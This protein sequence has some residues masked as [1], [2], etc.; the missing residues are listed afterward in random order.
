MDKVLLYEED[1]D[2]RERIHAELLKYAGQFGLV[3]VSTLTEAQEMIAG[4]QVTIC[5]AGL[6]PENTRHV[7][8][9]SVASTRNPGVPFILMLE[10]TT[11]AAPEPF[12][13][14]NILRVVSKPVHVGGIADLVMEGLDAIDEGMVWRRLHTAGSGEK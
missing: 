8:F 4:N 13:V 1:S 6:S 11:A 9:L 3:E 7:E 10:E 2:L 14:F 5:V 12:H